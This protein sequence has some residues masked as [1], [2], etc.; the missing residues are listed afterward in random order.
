M[1]SGETSNDDDE[2][3][4]FESGGSIEVP[5]SQIESSLQKLWRKAAGVAGSPSAVTRA[6]L[7]NLVV[8]VSPELDFAGAKKL[9]DEV[10]AQIPARVIVLR[11]SEGAA[12]GS[13][14]IRAWVEANW[15]GKGGGQRPSGSDEVTLM[16]EG[17]ARDRL[18]SLVR[19]LITP[20][21][22]SAMLW[23]GKPEEGAPAR[24]LVREIDRLIVDTRKLSAESDMISIHDLSRGNDGLE[25]AD[26]AWIGF[27]PL[28]GLTASLFDSIRAPGSTD[29]ISDPGDLEKIE[30]VEVISGVRGNQ[31][32]SL[33]FLGWLSDCLGWSNFARATSVDG[34]RVWTAKKPSGDSVK[35]EI[36]TLGAAGAHQHG[37]VGLTLE[38][39]DKRWSLERDARKIT[40]HGSGLPPRVQPSR[41][42]SD[43]DLVV[44]AL[45]GRGRDPLY[46]QALA[47]AV[48]LIGS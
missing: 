11:P 45:G 44:A 25:L 19:S 40:V 16:A 3:K 17:S 23:M 8:R 5:V 32:R 48:E 26:L 27:S 28:R 39:G 33:L 34:T 35:L 9:V 24:A 31:A 18:P 7:W 21:A 10:A 15:R 20:D 46:R 36:R 43:V 12:D 47:K 22:P 1:T 29:L 13:N 38:A 37:V 41:S 14:K 30:R 6:C 2:L 4:T 42:H